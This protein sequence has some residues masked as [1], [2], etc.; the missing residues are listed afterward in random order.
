MI[1]SIIEALRENMSNK[2]RLDGN[3]AISTSSTLNCLPEMCTS[4]SSR[5][6]VTRCYPV[7]TCVL[8]AYKILGLLCTE[9]LRKKAQK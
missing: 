6:S 2:M 7:Q 3:Q 9:S 1:S 4:K 8:E 5:A